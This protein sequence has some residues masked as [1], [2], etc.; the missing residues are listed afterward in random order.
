MS[1][2]LLLLLCPLLGAMFS[3]LR[4]MPEQ[5]HLGINAWVLRVAFPAL[6]LERIPTLAWE[7]QLVFTAAM[8]WMVL[9]G[10]ALLF[11][12]MGRW[13]G[14]DRRS[15]GALVLTCGLGNTAFVGLPMI[16]ALAGPDALGPAMIA[17][18]LGSFLALSTVGMVLASVY[19][20]DRV[21]L[22]E[23]ARRIASFP[24]FLAL[25]AALVVRFLGGWPE[26]VSEVLQRIGSTLTP[27]ALFSVG[28]SFRF[29]RIRG[30]L[31]L[32]GVGLAWKLI[33]APLVA[34][35]LAVGT[36]IGGMAMLAGVMQAA[37]GPMITAGLMA[38]EHRLDPEL[39]TV[40]LGTGILLS[41]LTAPLCFFLLS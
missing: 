35:G 40:V 17:D 30:R 38:Q 29:T 34:F 33:L 41:F 5:A 32:L 23:I 19:A 14:W 28:F 18:Q 11:P 24:P 8:P 27:L 15:V 9:L 31:A 13:M 22:R 6:L 26:M 7:S 12:L 21:H 10:A 3:R 2:F 1:A 36:G 25:V 20:G 16:L 4:W 37:Q 39:V